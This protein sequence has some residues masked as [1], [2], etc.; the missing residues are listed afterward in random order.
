VNEDGE[1]RWDAVHSAIYWLWKDYDA[2][3]IL[4]R[5]INRLW[6]H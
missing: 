3:P 5:S 6:D 2:L 4:R 1:L